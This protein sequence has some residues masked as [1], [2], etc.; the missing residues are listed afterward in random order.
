M[1]GLGLLWAVASS[2]QSM[3][4]GCGV[5]APGAEW[6]NC[7]QS[8][9]LFRLPGAAEEGMG[10]FC[11]VGGG[12][13]GGDPS[14]V[15]AL[16][17]FPGV[18]GVLGDG[19]PESERGGESVV[20]GVCAGVGRVSAGSAR[21]RAVRRVPVARIVRCEE[22]MQ[23]DNTKLIVCFL[24]QF[25]DVRLVA[26][27]EGPLCPLPLGAGC[28]RGRGRARGAGGPG[29]WRG[30]DR[31]DPCL[32]GGRGGFGGGPLWAVGDDLSGVSFMC[33]FAFDICVVFASHGSVEKMWW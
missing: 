19:E 31:R 11:G 27:P 12:R 23:S 3:A 8:H 10:K 32:R 16:P 29:K 2:S 21:S 22:L 4:A 6:N 17:E 20:A 30:P 13:V 1:C 33:R 5:C 28:G 15:P 25:E 7:E 26:T 14:V 24:L 9:C 18:R